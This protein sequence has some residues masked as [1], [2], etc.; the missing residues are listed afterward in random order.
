MNL[1]GEKV[2]TTVRL[3]DVKKGSFVN[4]A[5]RNYVDVPKNDLLMAEL[6][7]N[8]MMGIEN[9]SLSWLEGTIANDS[10][11]HLKQSVR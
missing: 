3:F 8:D 10:R 4:S 1:L 5:N 9:E 2:S 7:L 6:T 11:E